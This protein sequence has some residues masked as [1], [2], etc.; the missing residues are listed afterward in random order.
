MI[1]YKQSSANLKIRSE[2]VIL[3]A[4]VDISLFFCSF[5]Y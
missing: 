2:D 4:V 1:L 5:L 3:M